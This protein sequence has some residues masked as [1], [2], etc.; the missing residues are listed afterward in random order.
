MNAADVQIFSRVARANSFKGA[1]QYLGLTKAAVSKSVARLERELG[2]VLINRSPRSFSLTEAGRRFFEHAIQVDSALEAAIASV[3]GNGQ[4]VAGNLAVSMPT[5]LGAAVMPALIDRLQA[6]WPKLTLG[7]QFTEREV[8]VI[9]EGIDVA[10]RVAQ[11]L[12]D[13]MLLSK[14][15]G[16]TPRVLAAAPG[17]L[18]RH[19]VP[20]DVRD[21]KSHRCLA[22]GTPTRPRTVWRFRDRNH[23]AVE[24][25]VDCVVAA[26]SELMLVLAACMDGGVLYLPKLLVGGELA[27]GR[28]VQILPEFTD[29]REYGIYALYPNRNPPAKVR[30]FID[31]LL[32]ELPALQ[33]SDR[34]A[35]YP[36][37]A[38]AGKVTAR[39]GNGLGERTSVGPA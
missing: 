32:R 34:W 11:R 16:N 31:F 19:G 5:S 12:D 8:D 29:P 3:S 14:R 37:Q 39:S 1:A 33:T 38:V 20:K 7:V 15:L 26:D 4:E 18:A 25:P 9:G 2:V 22:L 28:L 10:I 6:A 30:A 23:G 17:Y 36:Q 27:Q 24:V 13:S 21:L 35:P